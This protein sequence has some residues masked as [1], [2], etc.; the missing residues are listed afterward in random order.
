MGKMSDTIA[1][2]IF[3]PA[4]LSA[5]NITRRANQPMKFTS[6]TTLTSRLEAMEQNIR[7]IFTYLVWS[8]PNAENNYDENRLW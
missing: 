8:D 6:A 7:G 2:D 1:L 4:A 3:Q 5:R